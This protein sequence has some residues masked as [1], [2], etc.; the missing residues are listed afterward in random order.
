MQPVRP[1]WPFENF[2]RPRQ[3][4]PQP[5]PR[6][7]KPPGALRLPKYGSPT[8]M[9]E[10]QVLQRLLRQRLK[11]GAPTPQAERAWRNTLACIGPRLAQLKGKA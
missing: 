1:P 8:E 5:R 11:A 3:P 7:G 10:L 2:T 9:Q 4:R 6:S